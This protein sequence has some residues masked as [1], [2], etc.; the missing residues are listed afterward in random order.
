MYDSHLLF[1]YH[2]LVIQ[3]L[4]NI[5]H[6][7]FEIGSSLLGVTYWFRF[8]KYDIQDAIDEDKRIK[9]QSVLQVIRSISL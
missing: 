8:N 6:C 7:S 4:G 3:V 2:S 1:K 5:H 9:I